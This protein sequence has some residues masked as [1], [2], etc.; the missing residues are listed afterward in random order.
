MAVGLNK[1][2]DQ[3]INRICHTHIK[4][5]LQAVAGIKLAIS[6][7]NPSVCQGGIQKHEMS[8]QYLELQ[9]DDSALI[10]P[11]STLTA[12]GCIIAFVNV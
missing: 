11:I 8:L 12:S 7:S 1:S 9:L 2:G 10:T 5:K 3:F 6:Y 4:Q